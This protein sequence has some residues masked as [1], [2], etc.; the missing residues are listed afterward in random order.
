[1]GRGPNRRL[2]ELTLGSCQ[3]GSEG[4]A[5]EKKGPLELD[6]ESYDDIDGDVGSDL[7]RDLSRNLVA[8]KTPGEAGDQGHERGRQNGV[9][10]RDP[11][12]I[13]EH[14]HLTVFGIARDDGLDRSQSRT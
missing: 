14:E 6:S 2:G 13:A 5:L 10:R 11:S 4:R 8:T 12:R 3:R 7:D 1:M 9:S